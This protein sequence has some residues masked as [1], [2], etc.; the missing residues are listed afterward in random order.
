MTREAG[1]PGTGLS[2]PVPPLSVTGVQ[3]LSGTHH[4][5][6]TWTNNG[7]D[8]LL[9]SAG[10]LAGPWTTVSAPW[11]TNSNWILTTVTNPVAA[12]FFRLHKQ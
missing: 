8:V 5:G 10:N 2:D 9:E 1:D 12:Q 4:V 11:S 6:L 7:V 3:L